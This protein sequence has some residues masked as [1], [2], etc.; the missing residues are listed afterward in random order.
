[1]SSLIRILDADDLSIEI[2]VHQWHDEALA[3]AIEIAAAR[4][5]SRVVVEDGNG[6]RWYVYS[7][8]KVVSVDDE[9]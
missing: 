6:E 8:G 5:D 3:R 7:T 4:R 9:D 2:E 1:M